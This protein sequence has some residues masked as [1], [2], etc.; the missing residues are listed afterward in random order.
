MKILTICQ[1]YYPEPFKIHEI[2]EKF[3][4][5]GHEVTVVT[6]RPNYPDGDLYTGYD[7]PVKIHE[8]INGVEIFRTPIKLRK[9]NPISKIQNYFS[10]PKEAIKLLK[11]TTFNFDIIFVYQLSPVFMLKPAI[12]YKENFN[13][14][15]YVYLLDLWPESLKVL[16]IKERNPIYKWVNA[17]CIKMYSACDFISVTSNSFIKYVNL[18]NKVPLDKINFIPQHGESLFLNVKSYEKRNKILNIV[19]AGNIGKAQDFKCLVNAIQYLDADLRQQFKITIIGSGSYLNSLKSLIHDSNCKNQFIFI[20]RVPTDKLVDYFND[21]DLFF[22]SLE[23]GSAV[24]KTIPAKL[25]TYLASGRAII[26]SIDGEAA[27]IIAEA[28]AGWVCSA[29]DDISLSKILKNVIEASQNVLIEYANNSRNYFLHHFTIDIFTTR[30]LH[31]M[32][33]LTREDNYSSD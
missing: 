1:Y 3:A 11:H 15:I 32:S 6:G 29:G 30:V 7:D 8:Y 24:S 9:K 23:K 20:N 27:K 33:E 10:Y 28:K 18:V 14:K 21:A 22:I 17:Q 13:T 16:S 5:L 26:G 19:Y 4:S 2:C 25:Q 12:F 31:R